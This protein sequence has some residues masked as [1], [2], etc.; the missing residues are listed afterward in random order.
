MRALEAGA[1]RS[2]CI[3]VDG[4]CKKVSHEPDAK[5]SMASGQLFA[6]LSTGLALRLALPFFLAGIL[7]GLV[8][9]AGVGLLSRSLTQP[10]Q[11]QR[12][13]PAHPT[14]GQ[15][16]AVFLLVPFSAVGWACSPF[17]CAPE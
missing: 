9:S 11:D 15:R 14:V 17:G 3:F 12:L 6:V 1:R 4:P 13:R 5:G 7:P 10:W 8:L 16:G 2:W